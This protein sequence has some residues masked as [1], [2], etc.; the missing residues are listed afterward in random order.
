MAKVGRPRKIDSPEHLLEL[1]TSYKTW[2]KDN[3]RYKYALNQRSGEMVAEPLECPLTMEG[4]EVYCFNKFNLT[5]EHYIRNTQGAYEEF[6]A[7]STHIKREI[8]QDQING[9]LVGQY[10]A[11]L[12]ARLNGLTEK[13]ENTIVTEQ[14]LFNFNV[15]GN[16]G[17]TENL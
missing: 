16:N 1:F 8:R 14:P 9:G 11:N 7:I 15:S 6:C 17:N 5:I 3:P 10:N 2:V 13:T 12:T 4:F